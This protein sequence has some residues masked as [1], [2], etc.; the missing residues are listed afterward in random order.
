MADK[1]VDANA[2]LAKLN[3]SLLY[4]VT[5]FTF[6]IIIMH[7]YYKDVKFVS[8]KTRIA[9]TK[10]PIESGLFKTTTDFENSSIKR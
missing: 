1:V 10:L 7:L 2:A 8:L 4:H 5:Y 9:T 3:D 6:L